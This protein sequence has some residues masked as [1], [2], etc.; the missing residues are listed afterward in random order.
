MPSKTSRPPARE[1][2]APSLYLIDTFGFVF[3]AFHALPSLNSPSGIPT[4]AVFGFCTMLDKLINDHAP[5][6]LAAV[7][8]TGKP[9]FRHEM[10]PLYK[11]NRPPTP[12]ELIPQFAYIE[13]VVDAFRIPRLSMDGFEADDLIAA[14]TARARDEDLEVVIVSS[15]KDLM[16]LVGEGVRMLDTKKDTLSGPEEVSKKFGVR[17][18]QLGDW[19]A[20]CGDSSDNVPGVPGVG[21][22]TA[23]KLLDQFGD[24]ETV[25]ASADEVRG[26]KLQQN[27]TQFADQARLSRRLVALRQDVPLDRD[28]SSL[29]MAEADRRALWDLYGELGFSRL[30]KRVSPGALMDRSLFRTVLTEEELQQCIEEIR[31]AGRCAVDVE[32]TSLDAVRARVV[33]ICLSWGAEQACY[34][35]VGHIYLGRPDQLSLEQ[36]LSALRPIL[37]DED[38]PKV[39]QNIKYDWIV[40]KQA[41][42]EMQGLQFDTMLASYVLDA[43]RNAHGLDALALDH[44]GHEMLSYKEV[45]GGSRGGDGGFEMVDLDT[46]TRYAAEDAEVT[47][48]LADLLGPR[49]EQDQEL[50]DLFRRMEMPLSRVLANMELRGVALDGKKLRSMSS[51]L[52]EQ[53]S[54]IEADVR[55]QAGWDVNINSPKQLQRLLFEDLGL[56][57]GRKTK[58]GFST[59]ADVL[60]DLAIEHPIAAQIDEYRTLSKLKNTYV[61]TLPGLVNP[62][63]GRVHTSYNQAVTATGRLSSSD[64]NLQN[65]PIRTAL[66]RQIREAFVAP[67]GRVF[68]SADYSQVELR[69]LAHLSQDPVLLEAF[70]EGQDVHLRTAA[71]VFGVPAGEVT[72]DQRRMAKAVN[73]GVI[74]GQTDWGLSRQLRIPKH[75]AKQYIDNYFDRYAGVQ[76]FMEQTIQ[77]ARETRTT[78]TLLGRRRPVPDINSSRHNVRLYAERVVRNTPIQGTAADL[79]KLAMLQVDRALQGA[80]LDAPMILTVHDELIFEVREADLDQVTALVKEIMCGALE[81][82]LPLKV[83]TGVGE[84]WAA[85]H[86]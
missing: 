1:G 31:A 60:A 57:A 54:T 10:Y 71:E 38:F 55:Q 79:M 5:R 80:G 65:I 48:R 44:L 42:L 83:D 18:E 2:A 76:Q 67:P 72:P 53:I 49:L 85:A 78:R 4:G 77:E 73:F 81:L 21:A 34:I 58:T 33:G 66:G 74:Y 86:P 13:Q 37:T 52:Q 47:L 64:P 28:L 63:T 36:V 51:Q 75:V 40:L 62:A 32:T 7:F 17:P 24:L 15:D 16:Q 9:T 11:A 69:V 61:D 59:D 25:L 43:S 56:R 8:D 68:L 29:V 70:Q 19:L 41:G 27:L 35:P 12:E 22:K 39:G 45:T 20:L 23:S 84:N 14:W 82:D 50:E 26:A 6:Y 30:R 3:R 46:A